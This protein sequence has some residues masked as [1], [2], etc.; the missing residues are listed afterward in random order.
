MVIDGSVTTRYRGDFV[1]RSRL[2]F[3][4]KLQIF[5]KILN[6]R[7]LLKSS[8]Y[9]CIGFLIFRYVLKDISLF[10]VYNILKV[11]IFSVNTMCF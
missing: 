10:I 5:P 2:V 3:L 8:K 7:P 1:G 4:V 6:F 11:S 9:K